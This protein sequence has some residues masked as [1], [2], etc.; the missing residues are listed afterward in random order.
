LIDLGVKP[1]QVAS[2]VQAVMAQRLIRLICKNCKEPDPRPNVN[3]LRVM[4]FSPEEIKS[5]TVYRG[6]G[7]DQCVGTGF[8]GRQGIFEMMEMNREIRELAFNRAPLARLRDAAKATGMRTLLLDGCL[9]V[10]NGLTTPEEVWRNTQ[11]AE[12]LLD[13]PPET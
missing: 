10:K 1:F 8:R 3:L 4:G 5:T 6:K 9:K 2:G 7:C 13:Q 11:S 12:M